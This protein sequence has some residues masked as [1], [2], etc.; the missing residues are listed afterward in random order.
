MARGVPRLQISE[1]PVVDGRWHRET[2]ATAPDA[3][4]RALEG[5]IVSEVLPPAA[6][7]DV[8]QPCGAKHE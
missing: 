4:T 8:V 5:D 2:P 7:D 1:D 3:D 6:E